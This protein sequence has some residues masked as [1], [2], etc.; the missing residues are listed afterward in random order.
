MDNQYFRELLQS[1]ALKATNHRLNLLN[2][3]QEYKSAMP[4]SALQESVKSMDRVTLYRTI[5]SLKEQGIIHKAFQEN[6]ESYYAICGTSCDKDHHNHDHIHFKCIECD[7][8]TC[9]QTIQSTEISIPGN[10]IH[11]IS[12]HI[13]G[14]CKLCKRTNN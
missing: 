11:K 2:K 3:M 4:Y 9:E 12:I 6:N 14:I 10:E 7:T 5:E 13:E 8:V 1:R